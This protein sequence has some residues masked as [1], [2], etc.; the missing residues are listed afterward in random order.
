MKPQT[1]TQNWLKPPNRQTIIDPPV[2]LKSTLLE[3]FLGQMICKIDIQ[4]T[5]LPQERKVAMP[6]VLYDS[7][8][9]GH[10]PTHEAGLT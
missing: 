5:K 3:I 7:F 10:L 6:P 8:Y 1:G 4:A 2:S 9:L